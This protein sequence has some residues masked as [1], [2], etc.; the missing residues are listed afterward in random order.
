MKSMSYNTDLFTN[1]LALKIKKSIKSHFMKHIFTVFNWAA[2]PLEDIIEKLDSTKKFDVFQEKYRDLK[3]ISYFDENSTKAYTTTFLK[4]VMDNSVAPSRATKV[5]NSN[6]MDI[7]SSTNIHNLI[8]Q[9]IHYKN[10]SGVKIEVSGRLTKRYR[11]DRAVST[12]KRKGGLDNVDSSLHSLSSILFRGN[13]N[14]NTSYSISTSKRRIGAF[15]VKG[16]IAG[17]Y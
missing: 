13:T 2:F 4:S 12:V 16:W 14:S 17:K 10:M 11:A 3:L 9:N 8:Y 5:V 7:V 15:A 6:T 1:I